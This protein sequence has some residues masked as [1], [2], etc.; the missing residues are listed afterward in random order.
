MLLL[1]ILHLVLNNIKFVCLLL[2]VDDAFIVSS[3]PQK[4]YECLYNS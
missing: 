2:R 3:L 1:Q 4:D